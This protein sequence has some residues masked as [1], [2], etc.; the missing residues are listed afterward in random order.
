MALPPPLTVPPLLGSNG[1]GAAKLVGIGVGKSKVLKEKK[2]QK[3]KKKRKRRN[4]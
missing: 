1:E 2:K 4:L 3:K